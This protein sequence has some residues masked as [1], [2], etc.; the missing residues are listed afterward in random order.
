MTDR[1]INLKVILYYTVFENY[2]VITRS[3]RF[4]NEGT[5]NIRLN[6]VMSVSVEFDSSDYDLLQLSGSWGR[7]RHI[8]R[9]CSFSGMQSVG[10]R[11]G[12]SSHQQNPF[13][14]LLSRDANE[15]NGKAYGFNLVYSGNFIAQAEVDQFK[16]TRVSIGINTFDFSWLLEPGQFFQPPEAVLVYSCRGLGDM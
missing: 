14:A 6:R 16:T 7:E 12:A 11:R 4:I 9:R 2:N 8:E 15:D 5:H 13:I 3:V 1:V 10:S